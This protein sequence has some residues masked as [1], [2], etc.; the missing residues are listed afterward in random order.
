MSTLWVEDSWE[1]GGAWA[2]INCELRHE[3]TLYMKPILPESGSSAA[4][5]E[6]G[7]ERARTTCMRLLFRLV[8][9]LVINM[10]LTSCNHC[11]F[12]YP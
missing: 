4:A 1:S 2:W 5:W 6:T 7:W 3:F 9:R 10:T 11:H 8:N 12:C